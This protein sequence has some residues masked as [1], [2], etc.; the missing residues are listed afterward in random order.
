M[1]QTTH[2]GTGLAEIQI[3]CWVPVHLG[4]WASLLSRIIGHAWTGVGRPQG[5]EE[6]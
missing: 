1:L 5:R 3:P 4:Q 2:P 6:G